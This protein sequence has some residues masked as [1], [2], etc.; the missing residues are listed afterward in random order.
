MLSLNE[1]I[2]QFPASVAITNLIQFQF[3]AATQLV[4]AI[5]TLVNVH[6]LHNAGHENICELGASKA[7][8]H[9]TRGL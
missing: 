1:L 3:K 4:G 8:P 6:V 2:Q 5:T 9:K 7:D